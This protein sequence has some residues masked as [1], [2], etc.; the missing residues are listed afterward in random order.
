MGKKTK[1][2]TKLTKFIEFQTHMPCTL[3]TVSSACFKCLAHTG[4]PTHIHTHTH[5]LSP[6][7]YQL[8]LFAFGSFCGTRGVCVIVCPSVHP[9]TC[10]P[11]V[12][13]VGWRVVKLG[14]TI[15][16]LCL[17]FLSFH[18][19]FSMMKFK[20]HFRQWYFKWDSHLACKRVK[21]CSF[22]RI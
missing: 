7:H 14:D 17:C 15:S 1:P 19:L 22:Y 2:R 8:H 11:T 20:M 10:P 5:R 18:S 13:C 4:T 21:Y 9:S 3:A 16:L 6:T 12:V